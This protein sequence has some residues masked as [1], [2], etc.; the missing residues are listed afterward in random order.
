MSYQKKIVHEPKRWML[1]LRKAE[2]LSMSCLTLMRAK[3][4]KISRHRQK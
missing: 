4:W 2:S 1:W 3:C